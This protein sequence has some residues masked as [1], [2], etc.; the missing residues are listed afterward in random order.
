MKKNCKG[1]TSNPVPQINEESTKETVEVPIVAGNNAKKVKRH[2]VVKRNILKKKTEPKFK[3]KEC[4]KTYKT[5]G[6]LRKHEQTHTNYLATNN[7]IL[8][9]SFIID[10]SG[11]VEVDQGAFETV[12]IEYIED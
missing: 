7:N 2:A 12:E 10:N 4:H 8:P 11:M 1:N 9:V 6:G 3:C 5:T